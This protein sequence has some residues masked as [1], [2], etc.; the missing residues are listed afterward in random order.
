MVAPVPA[1]SSSFYLKSRFPTERIDAVD[2]VENIQA[3]PSK[4]V[5]HGKPNAASVF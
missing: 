4:L 2:D 1:V 3:P 5:G